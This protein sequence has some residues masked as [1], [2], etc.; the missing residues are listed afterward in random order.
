MV[1]QIVGINIYHTLKCVRPGDHPHG[2]YEQD[3]MGLCGHCRR[4][5]RIGKQ[6]HWSVRSSL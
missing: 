1:L 3:G 2:R 5:L 6:I 4:L